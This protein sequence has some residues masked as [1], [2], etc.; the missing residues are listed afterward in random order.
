[1]MDGMT[2]D[3]VMALLDEFAQQYTARAAE[4]FLRRASIGTSGDIDGIIGGTYVETADP[5]TGE[6]AGQDITEQDI[7]EI[8]DNAFKEE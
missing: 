2:A 5:E 4:K 6:T 1:M 3:L 8:V 7:A